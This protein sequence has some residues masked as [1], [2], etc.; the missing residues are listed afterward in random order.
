[1]GGGIRQDRQRVRWRSDLKFVNTIRPVLKTLAEWL[2]DAFGYQCRDVRLF[3]AALTHRSMGGQHN[4]RLEFL[5][6]AVLSCVTADLLYRQFPQAPE[7]ELSRYRATLVSGESLAVLATEFNVG[8]R[9]QLG[10]GELKSGGFRR[11]SILADA[12]EAL[13]GAVYLDGGFT[14]AASVIEKIFAPRLTQLPSAAQLKDP[15]TRLQEALQSRAMA[16]PDYGVESVSGEPHAQHFS[17]S[18][19]IAALSIKTRG[20]GSSRR[21]AE[22][23]AAKF[24]IEQ[25]QRHWKVP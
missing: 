24:A 9:M 6:D 7:G 21:A 4:E 15:K 13:L 17:V 20:E 2:L 11:K 14:A 3:E 5:G 18:C 23:E 16:L 25:L 1:M 8:D 10:A 19:E 12:F 22:Q